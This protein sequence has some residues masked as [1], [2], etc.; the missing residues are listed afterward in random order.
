MGIMIVDDSKIIE[1]FFERSEQAII[2]LSNKYG[3]VC[4]RIAYNILN[5]RLD[6]EE[7]VN[8]AFL[9]VWNKIPPERPEQLFSYL[10]RIVRNQALK[11]YHENTAVKRNSIYD[12][13]LDE[14]LEFI[15]SGVSVES[16]VEA[17]R[18]AELINRFL[19]TQDPKN[20]II[21]VRRYWFCDSIDEIADLLKTNRNYVS[22]RL[23]RIRKALKEYL[24]KEEVEV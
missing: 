8:D 1:L 21:F 15:P 7:C 13:S 9:G 24:K 6:A 22:V 4:N 14:I 5:N 11:K 23:H 2:E 10:C 18:I 19:Q 17:N 20:R 16:Q 12:V 3:L